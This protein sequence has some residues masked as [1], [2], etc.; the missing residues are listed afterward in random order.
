MQLQKD[1]VG[2]LGKKRFR[3][4]HRRLREYGLRSAECPDEPGRRR[5]R[6]LR[7]L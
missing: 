1:N 2:E 4:S 3:A 5:G 6:V 7:G